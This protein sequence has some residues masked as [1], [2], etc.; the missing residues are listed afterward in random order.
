MALDKRKRIILNVI[1]AVLLVMGILAV[2][3][4]IYVGRYELILW[5]CYFALILIGIGSLRKNSTLILSQLNIMALPL[6]V[7]SIDFIFVLFGGSFLGISEYFFDP[8]YT[9]FGKIITS[10]H[11]FTLPLGLY[12]LHL[13]KIKK[14]KAWIISLIQLVL[15][16]L[17]TILFTPEAS[18]INC[19]FRECFNINFPEPYLVVW[20]ILTFFTVYLTNAILNN[21]NFLKE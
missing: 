1:G 19:V 17:L 18:N 21:L 7:W 14:N 9:I 12:A 10:Q 16:Y 20:F 15:I 5:L 3:H 11:L 8:R 13:L 4:A 6:I 2:S